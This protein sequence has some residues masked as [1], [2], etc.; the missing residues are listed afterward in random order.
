MNA[1][2]TE[3]SGTGPRIRVSAPLS[4]DETASV[5]CERAV[6]D[7][8]DSASSTGLIASLVLLAMGF[9]MG[10]LAAVMAARIV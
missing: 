4:S 3:V 10:V 5:C 2:Y 8:R 6:E 9:V 1:S 7:A